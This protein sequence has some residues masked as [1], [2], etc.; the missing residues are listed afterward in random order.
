MFIKNDREMYFY[1]KDGNIIWS[2]VP[3]DELK[4]IGKFSSKEQAKKVLL[5]RFDNEHMI[6]DI[7]DK[8]YSID[9]NDLDIPWTS[10][11]FELKIT[12]VINNITEDIST[13]T[14]TNGVNYD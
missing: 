3:K 9:V 2:S 11:P 6:N 14:Q 4:L 7:L 10:K 1:I 5:S 12:K 13:L 8:A